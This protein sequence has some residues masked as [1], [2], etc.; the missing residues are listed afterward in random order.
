MRAARVHNERILQPCGTPMG[1]ADRVN[2]CLAKNHH[3]HQRVE[4]RDDMEAQHLQEDG[5]TV[6]GQ[7]QARQGEAKLR[8]VR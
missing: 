6:P 4:Q 1:C 8:S 7:V 3:Q 2:S 5:T